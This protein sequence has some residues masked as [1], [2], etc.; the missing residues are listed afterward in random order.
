M[1]FK[2]KKD[3]KLL[4]YIHPIIIA[5][6]MDAY[7]YMKTKYNVELVVTQTSTTL[8]QDQ[9]LNRKSPAH[10]EGRALDWSVRNLSLEQTEDLI[11]YINT[12]PEWDKYKYESYSGIRRLAYFH[13]GNAPHI[14]LALHSRYKWTNTEKK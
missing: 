11:R 14:H 12:K 10:R 8:A 5:I 9:A 1:K 13:V 3:E 2:N 4:L 7:F 6:A